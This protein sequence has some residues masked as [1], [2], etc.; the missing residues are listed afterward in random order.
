MAKQES[1]LRAVCVVFLL[2]P[3]AF[4][5]YGGGSGTSENP[6][7]IWTAAQLNA[8]GPNTGDYDKY[9][10]LM[11]DIDLAGVNWNRIGYQ[12][13]DPP[14]T[15]YRF[16]GTFDGNDYVISNL[17]WSSNDENLAYI[18]MFGLVGGSGYIKDLGIENAVL[19]IGPSDAVGV[20]VGWNEG[21]VQ[22][23]YTT[24]S[25]SSGDQARYLGG[26][27]G[28]NQHASIFRSHSSANIDADDHCY[29]L[30]GLVGESDNSTI[31][32]CN[33]SGTVSGG[34]ACEHLGGL[35]GYIDGGN[36]VNS[37]STG[38]VTGGDSC[39]RLGGLT[40]RS[41]GTLSQCYSIGSTSTGD[42]CSDVGGAVGNGSAEYCYSSGPV[43]VGNDC[44]RI[45]GFIA[46]GGPTYD[47]FSNSSVQCGQN[48]NHVGGFSGNANH[49]YRCYWVGTATNVADQSRYGFTYEGSFITDSYFDIDVALPTEIYT[50]QA[51]TTAQM[52]SQST[53]VLWDFENVWYIDEGNDY[54]KLR[55][56]LPADLVSAFSM[57]PD[58]IE[59][60][61]GGLVYVLV[62]IENTN[63]TDAEESFETS[64]YMAD[65]PG[66]DWDSLD[67]GSIVGLAI[68]LDELAGKDTHSGLVVFAAP[69]DGGQYYLRAKADSGVTITEIDETNNWSGIITLIVPE[70]P[71]LSDGYEP[72]NTEEDATILS[73]EGTPQIHNI[74]PAGD[75]DWMR[76]S[77]NGPAYVLVETDSSYTA[78]TELWLYN[79]FGSELAYDDDGGNKL[80]S[81][82]GMLLDEGAYL[83][84]VAEYGNN[85]TI[86]EYSIAGQKRGLDVDGDTEINLFD[87][88]MLWA[89]WLND[90]CDAGN[91][92]CDGTDFNFDG[93]VDIAEVQMLSSFWLTERNFY[94]DFETGTFEQNNW[95]FEG[96]ADWTVVSDEVQQGSYSA[97]SGSIL[98]SQ[99]STMKTTV[100]TD[101]NR[102]SFFLKVSSE[103]KA[104]Y[105]KFY[106]DDVLQDKWSAEEDW[107]A[108]EFVITPG[109]H[110]FKWSYEKDGT[111]SAGADACWIDT[112]RT[113]R[114]E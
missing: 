5:Q 55:A 110:S 111:I 38:N 42:S 65:S 20:L 76:F 6:Y 45:G 93:V 29:E 1:V 85:E 34:N 82:I 12:Q 75:V 7:Q 27:V 64:L 10:I 22:N 23:C 25:V 94:E 53:Y 44:L 106:V 89:N 9:F 37:H 100:K 40:G 11:D 77:L 36:V 61:A 41:N 52:I 102:I 21:Y 31:L 49:I 92:G 26:L 46:Y 108:V 96:D 51:R 112:I 66:V 3:V 86:E 79:E 84:K 99:T 35:V 13:L 56:F 30:G 80:F 74:Y 39:S 103:S 59:T 68:Q 87:F 48:P 69:T 24:G 57:M 101:C 105:V 73:M 107:Q 19:S 32:D 95:E 114:V 33:S 2:T 109:T 63:I 17:S 47:C 71:D 88:Q 14:N 4:G 43:T 97:K 78:D 16:N 15:I 90:F 70:S 83:L 91:N 98:D 54:P 67:E 62:D 113:F 28:R 81:K 60:D 8:I 58:V 18:G 104:D 72:D 50:G